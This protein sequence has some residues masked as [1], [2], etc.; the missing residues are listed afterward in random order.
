[1]WPARQ[2]IFIEGAAKPERWRLACQTRIPALPEG[3]FSGFADETVRVNRAAYRYIVDNRL[4]SL[5]EQERL[6]EAGVRDLEFPLG[7][8]E[9]KAYWVIINEADKPRYH[10]RD[11]ER[12][13]ETTI[14]G[15]SAFHI[16]SK[17]SPTWFWST[18]EHVDNEMIWP[19]VYPEAFLG[20]SVPSS[21]SIA[22][23]PDNLSCNKIPTGFGLEGTKWENYRLRAT[24]V[25]WIDNR[26][27][28]TVAANSQLEFFIQQETSS[29]ITCHALAVRDLSG[30]KIP[31]SITK[32]GENP[33]ELPFGHVGAVNPE[34][35]LDEDGQELP[36]LGLDYVWTLRNAVREE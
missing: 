8:K 33:E 23:P 4:Y 24:Q 9:I 20:W 29:C 12:D 10:W 3:E 30:R 16:S 18:F 15:L 25:D 28:P 19:L 5:N 7:A 21:D 22:C 1:V 32:E 11:I 14:Y 34:L 36:Y 13:G 31:I 27:N 26:G 6:V 35:F 17:E 2:Q